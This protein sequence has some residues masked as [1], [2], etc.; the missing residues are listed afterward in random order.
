MPSNGRAASLIRVQRFFSTFPDRWPGLGLLLLR[1]L[2]GGVAILDGLESLLNNQDMILMIAL[3]G[4]LAV[5]SGALLL[6]GFLT[7]GTA[8]VAG[9]TPVILAVVDLDP[10][11]LNLAGAL[12]VGATAVAVILLGPGALSIDARLFG[13]REIV[14]ARDSHPPRS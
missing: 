7:P 6:A 14:F 1:V 8:S 9:L 10:P 3:A 12:Y 11:L 13:R 5:A 4:T 2:V